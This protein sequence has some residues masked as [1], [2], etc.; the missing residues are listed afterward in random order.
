MSWKS[1]NNKNLFLY[2]IGK[3]IKKITS[4]LKFWDGA[5]VACRKGHQGIQSIP[6]I[7]SSSAP[8]SLTSIVNQY[9]S[10]ACIQYTQIFLPL[11][12]VPSHYAKIVREF[13]NANF[14]D[15]WLGRRGPLKMAPRSPDLKPCNIF[16]W[17]HLPWFLY[18]FLYIYYG[19]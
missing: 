10:A 17:G 18:I 6:K 3:Y 7:F 5:P 2:I 9:Y 12:K 11:I 1:L 4:L 13:L 19:L 16:L 14:P 8:R 15:S